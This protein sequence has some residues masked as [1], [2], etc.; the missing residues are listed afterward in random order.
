MQFKPNGTKTKF[1][2]LAATSIGGIVLGSCG[3]GSGTTTTT[4]AP[5]APTTQSVA[6]TVI[7]GPIKGALVCLDQNGNGVCDTGE[8]TGT[9]DASGKV[10]LIVEKIDVGRFPVLAMVGTNAVDADTGA[11]PTPYVMKAP[12]DQ[13]S[14]ISPLTT[15]VQA[16][17]EGARV[18]AAQAEAFIKEQLGLK[19]SLFSDFT[20]NRASDANAA[21]AATV[22]RAIILATQQQS[23]VIAPVLGL[24]D[25][26]GATIVQRD[27]DKATSEAV[28]GV[29][30]ALAAAADDS[31]V[32]SAA[33]ISAKD[34]A[35]AT[36]TASIVKNQTGLDAGNAAVTIGVAKLPQDNSGNSTGAS[37]TLRSLTFKD[38]NN[39]FYRAMEASAADNI[40]DA[41]GLVR[42]ADVW[43]RNVNG[44]T[45]SWGF[46]S[47]SAR[48]GDSH[49]S[50]SAWVGCPLGFRST[51]TPRDANG[52]STY[53]YCDGYHRGISRRST[54]DIEG[55]SFSSV[56]STIQSFPGRD[57]GVDYANWG[58]SDPSALGANT[59]TTVNQYYP[60]NQSGVFWSLGSS[61][62]LGANS[63]PSGSKLYYQS[64]QRL[65]TAFAYDV[66]SSNTIS[67]YPLAISLGGTAA[68]TPTPACAAVTAANAA[69]F[70]DSAKTLEDI[71]ARNSGTSC[72]L[73]QGRDASGNLSLV[74]NEWWGNG[75]LSVGLLPDA[76]TPPTPYY[77][78]A[79]SLRVAFA[80]SGNGATFYRCLTR[81]SDN[82]VRNCTSI[83]SGTY[84][85][86]TFG[87][88]RV[89]TL[90]N[91]PIL[92]QELGYYRIFVERGGNVYFGY[93]D[94]L[95]VDKT[96]RLNLPAANALFTQLGIPKIVPN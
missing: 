5:P 86:Q 80:A 26:S 72:V 37:A 47:N 53:N 48:Q 8:P 1:L 36:L 25:S 92:A 4:I 58:P 78:N 2:Q 10:S 87:D 42:Y 14:V 23:T 29:L 35:L 31:S 34:A 27:L 40:P 89:L 88:A 82:S 91:P 9:T 20:Q 44:T 61:S 18:S 63:F 7:D 15:L 28:S 75:T 43:T 71:I 38:A 95:R 66:R 65:A 54:I 93:Q 59:S 46:N 13:T 33:G 81:A 69:T 76:V 96:A 64:N 79:A 83:G 74:N 19:G 55:Q 90:S 73:Q 49:W 3:G 85:I 57:S 50:G 32:S 84:G 24:K 56:V 6:I 51:Q 16:Q 39:W 62:S 52:T 21:M 45:T 22:A 77:S 17:V 70:L 30:P 11:V 60:G 94:M 12:S 67:V 68:A 41:N